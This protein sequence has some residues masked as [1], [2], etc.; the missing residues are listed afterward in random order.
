MK[1][2]REKGKGERGRKR[3]DQGRGLAKKKGNGGKKAV[4]SEVNSKWRK[5]CLARRGPAGVRM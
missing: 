4:K 3:K 1:M 5:V 2:T